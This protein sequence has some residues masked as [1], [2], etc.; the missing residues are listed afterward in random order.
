MRRVLL[1]CVLCAWALPEATPAQ[2]RRA[3]A[4]KPESIEPAPLPPFS[5]IRGWEETALQ[6]AQ[7][8]P[9]HP[10][11]FSL[12]RLSQFWRA[13]YD[14]QL[15]RRL[16]RSPLEWPRIFADDTPDPN[17]QRLEIRAFLD[18]SGFAYREFIPLDLRREGFADSLAAALAADQPVL[19]NNPLAAVIYGYD[20]REPDAWWWFDEAGTSEIVLESEW[21]ERFTYWSDSPTAGVGWAI[22]GLREPAKIPSDSLTWAWLRIIARSV[23]GVPEEGVTP[24]PL[25]LRRMQELLASSD[26]LPALSPQVQLAD[27]LAIGRMREAREDVIA[28][29]AD[30]V[31]RLRDTAVTEPLKLVQYHMHTASSV[32]SELAVTLYGAPAESGMVDLSRTW[33]SPHAR[34]RALQLVGDLLKSEKLAMESLAAALAA[35]DKPAS[36]STKRRGR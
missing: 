22:S 19:M 2:T 30:L 33:N 14:G 3:P 31:G 23:Q 27:P 16:N 10:V 7:S 9:G 1:M 8:T 34:G 26:S 17:R 35:H 4:K 29:A 15:L 5:L 12:E 25:S 28:L 18:A 11:A 21:T 13:P 20:R 32:L 6:T 36:S 24:Y